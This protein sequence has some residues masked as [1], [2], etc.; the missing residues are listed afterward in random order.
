MKGEGENHGIAYLFEGVKIINSSAKCRN[1]VGFNSPAQY[2]DTTG[3][4]IERIGAATTD[5]KKTHKSVRPPCVGG[6]DVRASFASVQACGPAASGRE[7]AAGLAANLD[8]SQEEFDD[9]R[10]R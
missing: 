8:E 10:V 4:A 7:M 1:L 3:L 9:Q 2:L 6:D 5:G